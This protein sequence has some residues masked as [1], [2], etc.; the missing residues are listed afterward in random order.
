MTAILM[1][2]RYLGPRASGVGRYQRELVSEMQ[3]QRPALDFRFIVRKPGDEQPLRSSYELE[4]DH[5]VYGPYTSLL[6]DR[7]LWRA[8]N[9]DLF[10]SPFHVMPRRVACPTVVSMHDAFHFE[11][12]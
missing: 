3:R 4:F 12:H 11:Q 7:Q 5:W 2:G 9:V 10:H 1:D 8:G 6:L